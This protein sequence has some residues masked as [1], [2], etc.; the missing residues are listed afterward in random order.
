M[1]TKNAKLKNFIHEERNSIY[2]KIYNL[3]DC[4][5]KEKFE[6]ECEYIKQC[7]NDTK[8]EYF[9]GLLAI[10]HK[11]TIFEISSFTCATLTTS[12]AESL[13][14]QIA[15]YFNKP[16]ELNYVLPFIEHHEQNSQIKYKTFTNAEKAIINKIPIL[17]YFFQNS[18]E[19]CVRLIYNQY[20]DGHSYL[21]NIHE[22]NELDNKLI[23]KVYRQQYPDS[24][25]LIK[26]H[27]IPQTIHSNASAPMVCFHADITLQ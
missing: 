5:S 3:I 6:K 17:Q 8:I 14:S 11:W 25:R 15:H 26:Y 12:R 9:N 22:E 20:L 21:V 16:Q 10:K 4:D 18:S 13:N 2:R 27:I 1:N 19:F 23:Y 24:F 7:F